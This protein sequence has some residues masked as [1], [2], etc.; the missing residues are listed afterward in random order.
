MVSVSAAGVKE[1]N[2]EY[3]RFVSEYKGA[4]THTVRQ[5]SYTAELM[6]DAS[7][8]Q[9][10]TETS[11]RFEAMVS[12]SE[13]GNDYYKGY[14]GYALR[15]YTSD[16]HS[17]YQFTEQNTTGENI[18]FALYD[19]NKMKVNIEGSDFSLPSS[20][21]KTQTMKLNANTSYYMVMYVKNKESLV[22]GNVDISLKQIADNAGDEMGEA[23][24]ITDL[25]E[26]S[27][28]CALEGYEDIDWYQFNSSA[29]NSYTS[30]VLTN[31]EVPASVTMT[32]YSADGVVMTNISASMNRSA[33]IYKKL[34]KGTVYYLKVSSGKTNM[35]KY[36]ILIT[37]KKDQE[38]DTMNEANK[39][40]IGRQINGGVQEKSD[41]DYFRFSSGDVTTLNGNISNTGSGKISYA[42][43]QKDGKNIYSGTI[44][45]GTTK[46][47]NMGGLSRNTTYY[48]KITGV[49]TE[50]EITID[51]VK[52]KIT[53]KLNGGKNN[54][55][56]S[57]TY[58]E[59]ST[60]KLLKPTRAGYSF[61]GW[62]RDAKYKNKIKEISRTEAKN[63]TVYAKWEKIEVEKTGI[64]K[65]SP[66]NTKMT[67]KWNSVEGAAG[68]KVQVSTSKKFNS[69][70]TKNISTTKKKITV[71]RLKNNTIYYVRIKAFKKD[72]AGN[73]IYSGW[74][75]T[76]A[77]KTK[78]E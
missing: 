36:S 38:N 1:E 14:V 32:L 54:L 3:E 9:S 30:I 70:T 69:K 68:Y 11:I 58:N 66:K 74:S 19:A 37:E 33:N 46:K 25:K 72:S 13:H 27:I 7:I 29:E 5:T 12:S 23:L 57:S 47:I 45:P 65:Y 34:A 53:Y 10:D 21:T 16:T 48:L 60:Y 78:K 39:I 15:I 59:T 22:G 6:D 2:I 55:N 40:T 8:F 62:Y 24:N 73:K 76:I 61:E 67:L 50:Y 51:Y 75:K 63:V 64:T 20:T 56:N 28:S 52:H 17:F 42:I 71:N 18:Q 35:G 31:N 44:S 77:V 26:N 49:V 43:Q 41:I 4:G